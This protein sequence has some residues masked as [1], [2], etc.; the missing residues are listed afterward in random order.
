LKTVLIPP[1]LEWSFLKQLPQQIACQF[2]RNN[3]KVYFC[4]NTLGQNKI[5]QV[6]PNLYVY[7]NYNDCISDLQRKKIKVDILYNT[8]AKNED[9]IDI[10][11]P[12][13][14]IY[15]SCDSFNEWKI[16]E[17]KMLS[18]SD[19]V[20]CTSAFIKRL[21]EKEHNNT[22]LVKNAADSS[23]FN[24]EY[25]IIEELDKLPKPIFGFLGATGNW[26]STYLIRKV[27]EKY[28]TVF[29]GKEF[30][31]PCPSN[32]I[33]CGLKDHSELIHWYNNVDAFLLPFNTKS[34][35][36]LAANP[37]KLF[38]YMSIGKPIIATSWE[39]TEQFNQEEKLIFTSKTDEEFM[40][41]VDYVANMAQEEKDLL[42]IKY[43]TLMLTN[44]WEDRF[45][46]I[47]Q[48][49]NDFAESKGIKL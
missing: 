46:Q 37:I 2:A 49:I 44:R 5:E 27:A 29:I 20:L 10:V 16:Y 35:I 15:H 45:N 18:K 39:E 30:G 36:T 8:W 41:N 28:T 11:K 25:K 9:W 23:L 4:N 24:E 47:E 14:T 43:K 40:Q 22:Y 42:K 32:V 17:N 34:E 1:I 19:I 12:Q 33:N 21:R 7:H 3:Y 38:E 31:K 26:V 6:E 13:I 48:A